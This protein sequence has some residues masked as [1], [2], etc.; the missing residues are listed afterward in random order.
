MLVR[1]QAGTWKPLR[2]RDPIGPIAL[3]LYAVPFSFA[4][5]RIGAAAGALVLFGVVQLTMIGWGFVLLAT[6]L[7]STVTLM[8]AGLKL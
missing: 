1:I 7:V 4:Y 6:G 2:G 3:F 5:L 8:V